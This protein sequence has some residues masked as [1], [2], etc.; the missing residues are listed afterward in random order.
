MKTILLGIFISLTFNNIA[1]AG[2]KSG[3]HNKTH[4]HRI[5]T[6]DRDYV[7]PS[8]LVIQEGTN[9]KVVRYIDLDREAPPAKVVL[10]NFRL[11][12]F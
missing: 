9:S 11:R 7:K 6:E 8:G 3:F 5:E 10:H 1:I 2:F 4:V 12:R